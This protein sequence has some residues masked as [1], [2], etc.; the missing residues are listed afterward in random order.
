M[1]FWFPEIIFEKIRNKD[2]KK[3]T[4][5]AKKIEKRFLKKKNEK[6]KNLKRNLAK[7]N[8]RKKKNN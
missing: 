1:F 7:K 3:Q 4:F 2:C 6:R 8:F 5:S